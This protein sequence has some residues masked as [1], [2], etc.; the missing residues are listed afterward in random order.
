MQTITFEQLPSA[1]VELNRKIDILLSMQDRKQEPSEEALLTID[2]L[3]DYLPETPAR[4]TIYG[5]V[6]LRLIPYEKFGGKRLY[7]KKSEIDR[8][9]NNGRR[10]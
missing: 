4:Q 1:V 10:Q 9:L 3:R 2:Q 8:W 5:W 6:N 7:F